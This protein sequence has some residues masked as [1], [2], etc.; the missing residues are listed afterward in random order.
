MNGAITH[1]PLSLNGVIGG[2]FASLI[3]FTEKKS[4]KQI[5]A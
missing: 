2:N 3:H 4:I 5:Y 1:A